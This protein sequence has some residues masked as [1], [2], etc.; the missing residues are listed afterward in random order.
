MVYPSREDV[1]IAVASE[2]LGYFVM[3]YAGSSD[4]PD[5]ELKQAFRD[6]ED[7]MNKFYN[8]LPEVEEM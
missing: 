7:A 8:L 5:A 2:G 3:D 6:A 1:A 4:M